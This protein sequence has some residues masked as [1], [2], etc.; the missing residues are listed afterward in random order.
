[1]PQ[2]EGEAD[3]TNDAGNTSVNAGLQ[4]ESHQSNLQEQSESNSNIDNQVSS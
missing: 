3:E 2:T 4:A 1:M